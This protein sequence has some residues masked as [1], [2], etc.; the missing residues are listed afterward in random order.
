MLTRDFNMNYILY[1]IETKMIGLGKILFRLWK[2]LKWHC[3]DCTENTTSFVYFFFDNLFGYL[4]N[5]CK[6]VITKWSA[7]Y[8]RDGVF[9]TLKLYNFIRLQAIAVHCMKVER[10]RER[11]RAKVDN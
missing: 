4:E 3:L 2:I 10:E 7:I 6:I 8:K 11:E 1:N 9:Q 5:Y